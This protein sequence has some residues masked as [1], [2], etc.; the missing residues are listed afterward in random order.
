MLK[1][2]GQRAIETIK[3]KKEKV[4]QENSGLREQIKEDDNEIDNIRDLYNEL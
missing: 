4:N 1:G 3:E 2:R